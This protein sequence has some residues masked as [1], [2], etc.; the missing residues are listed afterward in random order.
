M[1]KQL[2]LALVI[3]TFAITLSSA[4]AVEISAIPESLTVGPNDWIK[5]AIKISDY[6]GGDVS[7]KII[8]PD[9]S[10]DS[11]IL[12]NLQASK[13]NHIISRTAL[14]HQFGNWT[15]IYDYKQ[16]QKSVQVNVVPLLLKLATDKST[17]YQ[18]EKIVLQITTNYYE[19]NASYGGDYNISVLDQ[20]NKTDV[21]GIGNNIISADKPVITKSFLIDDFL[22]YHPPGKYK[23]QV[24]YFG[25]PFTTPIEIS[26]DIS[27]SIFLGTDKSL[28]F[29]GDPIELNILISKLTGNNGVLKVI[30]P[31]GKVVDK[32]ITI[33][34]QLTK[35]FL[36]DVPTDESGTYEIQLEYGGLVA[37][38]TYDIV[39]ETLNKPLLDGL[40][41]KITLDKKYYRP[42]QNINSTIQSNKIFLQPISYWFVDPS[43]NI[44]NVYSFDGAS[45]NQIT[46]H[47]TL[48][49]DAS[50]GPWKLYVKYGLG[51]KHQTFVV[52]GEPVVGEYIPDWIRSNAKWWSEN[53]I[54]DADFA[55]GLE[56][57]IKNKL[58]IIS[59][60]E[61]SSTYSSEIP[62]WI[63]S[64][65]KWWSENKITDN[66]FLNSLA[67][68]I[69]INVIH[70]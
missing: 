40:D 36:K 14:D 52:R 70:I 30:T 66:E 12:D 62:S 46:L 3:L 65:A 43:G 13:K 60:P 18:G 45:S 51:E 9:N 15:I 58:I 34:S 25:V 50:R 16:A 26:D 69:R 37:T 42:G 23:I 27:S 4:Y 19:Q 54:S 5:I 6:S 48:D 8:K 28:Y 57:L 63:R 68:L 55:Q 67:Y 22:N 10:T 59:S 64:N 11:G 47:H 29:H 38:K 53:K 32:N 1:L 49:I 24:M 7:Y 21:L 33:D 17:Y 56:F 31:S 20:N 39:A 44:G 35:M 41:L 2:I 61:K